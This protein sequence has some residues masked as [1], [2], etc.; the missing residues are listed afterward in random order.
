MFSGANKR[1]SSK[2]IIGA[3]CVLSS[4]IVILYLALTDPEFPSISNL[5]EFVLV[6]GG[7]LLGL[8]LAERRFSSGDNKDKKDSDESE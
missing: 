1:L 5:L 3:F 7:G 8:G 4:T 6:T 2:R